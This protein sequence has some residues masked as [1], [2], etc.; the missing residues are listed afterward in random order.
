MNMSRAITHLKMQLGL[1]NL[2]LPFKDEITGNTIP[3]ENVIRDVLVN[4]TIPI[5]SQYKPW[6]R[7]GT[8]DIATLPLLDRKN[9]IYML[10]AFLTTTP[11]MYVIDVS[12]PNMNTRGTYGDIA[13]A[14]GINRS[15]QGVITSQEYMMLA[16]LMRAEPT[17][18]YLGENKIKLFGF[19]RTALDFE[20][21]CEHEPNGETIP[22]SCYDSFMQLAML[23]TKMFLY[24]TLKLYDGIPS[25]FGS[26]QL[27]VEELQGA[28]SERTALLNQWNDTF[29]L[30]LDNWEFF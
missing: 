5:Y 12:M 11:V 30:D 21:A 28:D 25:A 7:E 2:S 1:Y 27:K 17:F 14:Y 19:P 24:N 26:I 10:P 6:I 15:V 4:V 3:V 20:V 23:D 9:S 18:E 13:P 16:G 22:Y 8:Q 29:H